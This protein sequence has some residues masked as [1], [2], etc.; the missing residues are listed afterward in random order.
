MKRF[1]LIVIIGMVMG[2]SA[3]SKIDINLSH[4]EFL[5]DSFNI[6]GKYYTGY[7]IYADKTAGAYKHAPAVSEGVTC[8]DDVARVAILYTDL[9]RQK[10]NS[11][12][13]QRARE[14]LEFVLAM[15]DNDGDF[16]NFIDENGTINRTG[17]TSRKSK[18]W[19][20]ARAFWS[21]S[22]GMEIFKSTDSQFYDRLSVAAKSSFDLLKGSLDKSFLINGYTDVSSVF[23]LGLVKYYQNSP[24]EKTLELAQSIGKAIID[25]QLDESAY[26]G[27]YNESNSGFAWHSW[28]SR[29]AQALADLYTI[30]GKEEYIASARKYADNWLEV[31]LS[32]GPIYEVKE[33]FA[34]YPQ[35]AYGAEAAS[36]SCSSIFRATGE[37]RYGYLA[38]LFAGFFFR[39]NILSVPMYGKN[40][41]GYDGLHSVYINSNAGAES[42]ISAL[43][44]LMQINSLDEKFH[45]F[46]D[47]KVIGASKT[48]LMEAE[49]FDPGISSFDIDNSGNVRLASKE[50]LVIKSSVPL[51]KDI[52]DV[53][54][55]GSVQASDVAVKT[56]FGENIQETVLKRGSVIYSLAQGISYSSGK[57][58]LSFT[59]SNGYVYADQI[60][61]VPQVH[62][63][64]IELDGEFFLFSGGRMIS[65]DYTLSAQSSKAYTDKFTVKTFE[66]KGHINV[67]LSEVF[68]NDGIVDFKNRREGNFDNPEG[69]FGAKYSQEEIEKKKAEG[70][71][72][73]GTVPFF[74]QTTTKDNIV[75]TG[76]ELLFDKPVYA[77]YMYIAGSCDHGS[78]ESKLTIQYEDK[79]SSEVDLKFSDW[80]QEPIY[81][82]STLLNGK[83]RY[84]SLGIKENINPKI[85]IQKI[86]LSPKG[87]ERIY[88]PKSPTMHIF[89]LTFSY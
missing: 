40:G 23:L 64:V 56:Y 77:K 20:A 55:L 57:V 33:Y 10:S 85:F 47:A 12:Y 51:E 44:T 7:W 31:L 63:F 6:E 38:A 81:G 11:L 58:T 2:I 53:Y 8:V 4:L 29:Q 14:A 61:F 28:G 87:T 48:I 80:C 43:L 3:F 84:T 70:Y 52:Y 83:Y 19:W 41:E 45:R 50:K 60:L 24:D 69:V 76:Q 37:E 75:C 13:M 54:M 27:V 34:L 35:I 62:K 30:C 42:T 73:S 15:Q 65:T 1:F 88:L 67:D 66:N 5:K 74:I 46:I 32:L 17:I 22:N 68:N 36:S 86:E 18:S 26:K 49:K 9:Y 71:I 21:I 59:P 25:K 79:S 72:L 82:E 78:Y 39:N 89:A 16:Y